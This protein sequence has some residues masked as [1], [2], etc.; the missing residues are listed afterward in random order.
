MNEKKRDARF[1]FTEYDNVY[2]AH[3]IQTMAFGVIVAMTAFLL[4]YTMYNLIKVKQLQ[5]ATDGEA[6]PPTQEAPGFRGMVNRWI[7]TLC[8]KKYIGAYIDKAVDLF[9]TA[10]QYLYV[11][12]ILHCL[13]CLW[14]LCGVKVFFDLDMLKVLPANLNLNSYGKGRR[15]TIAE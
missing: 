9:I 13:A 11:P 7:D 1:L 6:P 8:L 14:F 15:P 10:P 12:S 2:I 3:Q 4:R 5:E